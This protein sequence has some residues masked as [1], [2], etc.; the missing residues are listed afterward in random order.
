MKKNT[1]YLAM[2]AGCLVLSSFVLNSCNT[3]DNNSNANTTFVHEADYKLG[4]LE[5]A[6]SIKVLTYKMLDVNGVLVNATGLVFVPKI[7]MPKDG[8]R[9]V[10]WQHGT[11]GVGDNCAPSNN[12]LNDNFK[13]T[14]EL[15]LAKGYMIL[16]PDYE[17]LGTK[18]VH[19]YLNVNSEA[20]SVFF[21][22]D[23]LKDKYK[24]MVHGDWFSL[25]Q[26]QGGQSSVA[27]AERG[28]NDSSF[29][30]A[31]AAAPASNLDEIILTVAPQALRF[32]E[33]SE[34]QNNIP[35]SDR[36]S[37]TSYATLLTY[38]AFAG[39]GIKAYQPSY[40]FTSIFKDN[41]KP[42]AS[43]V[44]GTD[45]DNGD[46]L[47]EV[48]IAIKNDIVSYL[49]A[50]PSKRLNDYPGLDTELFRSDVTLNKFLA[51]NKI[52]LTKVEKP[53]LIIQ[54]TA[55]TN[56]PVSM[57]Q[58]MYNSLVEAGSTNITL[59]LA[60]GQSHTGAILSKNADLVQ[61]IVENMPAK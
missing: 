19:P 40:D 58:K 31:V 37:I 54:G 13:V 3:D 44:Y 16:A 38:T 46:C 53:L 9:V 29:K 49:T 2:I 30:G 7:E 55:D 14:A 27:V 56:V 50:N 59:L 43:L 17:G 45:G 4:T 23:A 33:N 36:N 12:A 39:A 8:Y 34:I 1:F 61:F 18:G 22:V 28:N 21:A 42:F 15:L 10:V 41:V 51:S 32:L 47:N 24:K 60:E 5:N 6:S 26:S 35:L 57:T 25:G 52:G 48:R 11:V 20:N